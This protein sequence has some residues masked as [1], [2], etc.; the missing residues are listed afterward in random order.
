[1]NTTITIA[2]SKLSAWD[3]NVRKTDADAGIDELAAS[4]AAHG[5]LQSL[6]VTKGKRSKYTVIAGRRRYLALKALAKAGTIEA[7]ALIPCQLASDEID[8]VEL[9]LAEN[10]VRMPMHPADQFEAFRDLIGNGAG[11]A[12]VAARFS[13]P[14][15]VVSKR[16]KLGKL[17]PVILATYRAGRRRHLRSRTTTPSRKGCSNACPAGAIPRPISGAR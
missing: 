1:M 14:E 12:D 16:L 17:S 4:I 8:P 15:S 10:I 13:V 6:V 2:L 9:S 3:G 5:L 7:D 11:I